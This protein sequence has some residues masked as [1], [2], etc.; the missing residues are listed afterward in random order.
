[1]STNADK[2]VRYFTGQFLRA[3]D[4]T[5]EQAYHVDRL[6]RH[7]RQFHTPGIAEGLQV[8]A[9]TGSTTVEVA[10]GTAVDAEGHIIVLTEGRELDVSTHADEIVIV[11]ISYSE[12]GSDPATAGGGGNTRW[13]ERPLVELFA[14]NAVPSTDTHIHL[15][16]ITITTGGI[17]A[18]HD[19]TGR[20]N[21]GVRLGGALEVGRLTITR[22]GVDPSQWPTLHS[23]AAKQVDINGTLTI[24]DG[25]NSDLLTFNTMKSWKFTATGIDASTNL[26]LQSLVS[27]KSF[28]VVSADGNSSPL[29][30]LTSNSANVNAVYLVTNGGNVGIG[31]KTP[32][33]RVDIH[34]ALTFNGNANQRISG[35]PRGGHDSVVMSGYWDELEVKGRVIDWTGSNLHIGYENDHQAHYIEMGR[36][37]GSLHFLSGGGADERMRIAS[38]GNVGIGTTEPKEKLEISGFI[39]SGSVGVGRV[40]DVGSPRG[41]GSYVNLGSNIHAT[42][43][44]SSNLY[45]DYNNDDLRIANDHNTMAGA[46]I[47]IPGN[48]QTRQNFIEFWTNPTGSVTAGKPYSQSKP[49]MVI[50]TEGNVGIGTDFPAGGVRLHVVGG[51]TI[52]EQEEWHTPSLLYGWQNYHPVTDKKAAGFF[53]DSQGIIHLRGI[54]RPG[55]SDPIFTLPPGYRPDDLISHPAAAWA[56]GRLVPGRIRIIQSG[57]VSMHDVEGKGLLWISLDGITFRAA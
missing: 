19:S 50:N 48:G 37:V 14:E 44:L 12:V 31:T 28:R 25:S 7:Q 1:M 49:R 4:F 54:L 34:G 3:D 47:K 52:L 9:D 56:D 16:R 18:A 20:V 30:V 11:T 6:R 5:D 45:I 53:K 40:K 51:K 22:S 55:T 29:E 42:A 2:R 33:S 13:H 21:A 41:F 38:D 15:A 8:T 36:N 43:L 46:A 27:G 17:I 32:K 23:G 24:G 26:D 39:K 35:E 57:R 10:P